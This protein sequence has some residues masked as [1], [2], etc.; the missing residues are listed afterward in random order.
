MKRILL[1]ALV[2][3]TAIL[4]Q[5][6]PP[7]GDAKPGEWY[8]EKITPDGAVALSELPAQ[9]EKKDA[10]DTKIKAK[11][12][13]VCPKKGCWLKLQVNDSTTAMVKMKDYGFFL[14]VAAKGKTVVI[15]GEVKMKTIS[16]AELQHYAEDAKKSKEEIAAITKPEKEIRVTAKGIVVVE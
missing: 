1:T 9:L 10:I 12:L 7:A 14:P 13:E 8:G 5:A 6:Q 16:V 2:V 4:A 3:M 15:D 11:I